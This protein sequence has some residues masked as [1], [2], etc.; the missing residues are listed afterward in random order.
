MFNFKIDVIG[1]IAGFITGSIT[2]QLNCYNCIGYLLNG[3]DD[4]SN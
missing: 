1:Y 3:N 2:K 4:L